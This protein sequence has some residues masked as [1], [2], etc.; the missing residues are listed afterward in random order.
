MPSR[1]PRRRSS[2]A[3]AATTTSAA[4]PAR[5]SSLGGSGDDEA[6]G[7]QGADTAFLGS[8]A[9]SFTW[10]PGDG[11]DRVEGQWGTDTLVFNGSGAA[12]DFDASANGKRLRFFRNVGNI[13]M[14]VDGTERVDLRA[15]G[16]ADDTVVHD[17]GGTDVDEL[18][19][20]LASALGGT[21]GDGQADT[22]TLFG[23]DRRGRGDDVQVQGADGNV[24][25]SGLSALVRITHAE[26]S[27]DQLTVD[28]LAGDDAVSG[29][30]LASSAIK[31]A[32]DG[33]RD[34]DLLFGSAGSD[35]VSGGDGN[36]EIDGNQ[37]NDT[38]SLGSGADSFTWDPGDGSDVV[39]GQE[40]SD[41]MIFNGSDASESFEFAANGPRLRFTRNVGNIVM[42][43]DDVEQVDLEALGGTDFAT[44]NDLTGTG[45]IGT[46]IDLAGALGSRAGD[47][48]A[49]QIV[50]NGTSGP[51]RVSISGGWPRAEVEGLAPQVEVEHPEGAT[52]QLSVSTLTGSDTV[53]AGALAA[54][55]IKLTIDGGADGDSLAGSR[56]G[57]TLLG[58][59]AVDVLAGNAGDDD[60]FGGTGNDTAELGRGDD[61]FTWDPGDGSDTVEG[62]R[63]P[64]R[65]SSTA[66]ERARAS[67]R[68]RTASGFASSATS[69]TS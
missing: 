7:N 33:G 58:G 67:T 53:D 18:D 14:D 64:T 17:L 16:G 50:V 24:S 62:E 57:D 2:P 56:G 63:G 36:D 54:G 20:D 38:A 26:A 30:R 27:L 59:A 51:D 52:D 47:G 45:V 13:V 11:S 32:L 31:L 25:V 12:E 21:T 8:G 44:V 23:S 28:T 41:T 6:D 3:S 43:V 66:R 48:Q 42:D 55:V 29:V 5:R 35:V 39:E 19:L 40:G 34:D 49:D 9:D 1:I 46:K 60:V 69:A 65:S 15:L 61:H 68:P 22:V 4:V 10:D 37:G